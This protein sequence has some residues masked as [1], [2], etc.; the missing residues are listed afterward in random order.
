MCCNGKKTSRPSSP[1]C[2][3]D[4][5]Y[6]NDWLHRSCIG[7]L[8]VSGLQ[9]ITSKYKLLYKATAYNEKCHADCG[10]CLQI[11]AIAH[12]QQTVITNTLMWKQL[13]F[14]LGSQPLVHCHFQDLCSTSVTTGWMPKKLGPQ[15]EVD[16]TG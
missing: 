5:A 8:Q 10:R 6:K 11:M 13:G 14:S 9:E 15:V 16:Q 2:M 1:H 4:R 3:P 12:R 7:L